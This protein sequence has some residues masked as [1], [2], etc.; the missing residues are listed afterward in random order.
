[1]ALVTT[2][3]LLGMII[4]RNS[5]MSTNIPSYGLWIVSTILFLFLNV[6]SFWTWSFFKDYNLDQSLKICIVD[7]HFETEVV[8]TWC[9]LA[10]FIID[11][12]FFHNHFKDL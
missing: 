6:D 12:N 2:L 7:N 9:F 1:M 11:M 8:I 5:S 4:M 10:Y 3:I